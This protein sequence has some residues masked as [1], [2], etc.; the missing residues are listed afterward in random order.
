MAPRRLPVIAGVSNRIPA[1]SL[2]VLLLFGIAAVAGAADLD[3]R[4]PGH[5]E[6]TR[7][8]LAKLLVTDLGAPEDGIATGHKTVPF[9]HIEGAGLTGEPPAT[10]TLHSYNVET[11]SIL[12]DTSRLLLLVDLGV[13]DAHLLALVALTPA[14]RVVHVVAVGVDQFTDFPKNPT[15]LLLTLRTPLILIR[16]NHNV[17]DLAYI[18]TEMLFV[19]RDRFRFIDTVLAVNSQACSYR[20]IETPSIKTV[21]GA[22][23]YAAIQ[24]SVQVRTSA[25]GEKACGEKPQ[26]LGVT[27]YRATYR[28][29]ERQQRFRTNSTELKRLAKENGI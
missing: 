23:P 21:R 4:V 22:G 25:T 9:Q 5:P 13:A 3:D 18:W 27:T 6:L 24:V 1:L 12:D 16:S 26:K 15:R 29:D 14:P 17:A 19:R 7:L 20:R 11:E 8:G 2:A 28:W 10:I